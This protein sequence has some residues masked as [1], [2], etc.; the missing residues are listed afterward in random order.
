VSDIRSVI[1]DGVAVI[2][3]D[4]TERRN[5]LNLAAVVAIE[6]AVSAAVD[7]G[8][9][10]IIVTGEGGHFCAGADLKEMEDQSFDLRLR[11]MLQHV[12]TVP[13][14]TFAAISG[15]CMGLGMQLAL[16]CDIR[17]VT[18]DA[19]FGIPAGRLGLVV[20]HWTLQRLSRALGFGAARLMILAAETLSEEDAWRLGFTQVRGDIDAAHALAQR[21]RELAPLSLAG[22]KLGLNLVERDLDEPAFHEAFT[23]AW[24]SEDLAEGQLAFTERRKPVFKGR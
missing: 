23:K 15:A 5:A 11:Q 24:T 17:V 13:V 16:A 3:I 21:V 22:S 12:A 14:P 2:T 19:Y 9:A 18:P 8:V 4:R 6:D 10:A 7:S 20:N 1:A